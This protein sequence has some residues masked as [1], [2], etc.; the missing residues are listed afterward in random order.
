MRLVIIGNGIVA[1]SMAYGLLK[2]ENR[3]KLL[4]WVVNRARICNFSCCG[5][6]NSFAEI[7]HDTLDDGK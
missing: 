7:E 5:D 1:M 4:L 6:V 2:S 3:E